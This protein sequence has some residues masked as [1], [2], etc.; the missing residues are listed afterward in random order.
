MIDFE[1]ITIRTAHKA[2]TD[3]SYTV[4][5]LTDAYLSVI[6]K[7]NERLNVFL[8]M[9]DTIDEQV[10][11]A[12]AMFEGGTQTLL[13]GIPFA[14]KAN[15]QVKGQVCTSGSKM[16]KDYRAVYDATA[17]SRLKAAGAVLL[18]SVNMDEFAMG[19]STENSAFGPTLNPVDENRVPGGSSGG[20]AAAVAA[21]MALVALGTDTGGSVRQP[22]SFTGTVGFKGSYGAV[23]RYGAAAMGSSLDQIG[24]IAKSVE[25]A[26]IVFECIRGQ[27]AYDMTSLPDSVWESHAVPKSY[28]IA[29]PENLLKGIDRSVSDALE[30]T[31]AHIEAKGHAIERINIDAL[32]PALA[33]YYVLMPA[34][35]SSNMARYDGIRYGYKADNAENLL[36]DYV[37]S[38]SQGFG[39]EVKRRILLGTYLLSK[40]YADQ[41]YARAL[42]IRESIKSDL[43]SLF[44]RYDAVLTPTSPVLPF[45]LGEKTDDPL[46]MYL[47]DIFT[48]SANIGMIPAISVPAS[49]SAEGLP[50]GMQLMGKR[51]ND[52]ELLTI[53]EVLE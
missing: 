32:D 7:N 21:N 40:G 11:R 41:Y 34:E 51:N 29:V 13:T 50:I 16:L 24:P 14:I 47:A 44:D 38:R 52:A 49:T 42:A 31:I 8:N 45:E 20:S 37:N 12:Q 22:A 1:N 15:I 48:V 18:G 23:P 43:D 30:Q 28:T 26:R 39:A 33:V 5:E 9:F 10:K 17:I 4:R 3:G 19:S 2:F 6:A 36:A 53:A 25:D 27:G 46:A 35:V